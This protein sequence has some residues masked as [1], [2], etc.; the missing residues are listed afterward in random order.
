MPNG[1]APSAFRRHLLAYGASEAAG[2]ISRL[3][4]VVAV[5]RGLDPAAIGLA[6]A[7][8]AVGDILK[9]LTENGVGQRIVAAREEDLP[10]V[11]A[12]AHRIYWAWSLGLFAVQTLA[13]CLVWT[14][15]GDVLVAA[16]IGIL[17]AEY[18]FMPGGLVSCALA[19]REGKLSSTAAIAGG[20]VVAANMAT[21]ALA[22]LWA[23]PL[24]LVLPRVLSAP[25]WLVGMRRLR[26]WRH[27]RAVAPA[28]A[29]PFLRYGAAV[30]GV[31]FVKALRLHADKLVIGAILGA[32][33]LG[34]YFFA[35]N[36]GLGLAS[37]FSQAF[38]QVLFPHLAMAADRERALGSAMRLALL[39][40]VPVVALQSFA[41]PIYVPIL[42]G[43]GWE[44]VSGLVSILCLAAIPATIW[45]AA[46]QWLRARDRAGAE[47][48]ATACTAAALIGAT[49]A[50]APLGLEAVAIG[51]LAVASATQL[52][53]AWSAL[54]CTLLTNRKEA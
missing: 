47:F 17:G 39:V 26:P 4:V 10:A 15:S 18:L 8:L 30:L 45:T 3:A 2:K 43:A 33:A 42:F 49:A 9:A 51:Y 19:M 52:A 25:I 16:M 31:E 38:A 22:L 48:V 54:R 12:R 50:F 14:V 6:A 24:A 53:A 35:F 44:D 20:Q 5:A 13:A 23:N 46:A 21:A 36:A 27:D 1:P 11:C 37:S 7:A 41:A 29:A 28:P 32:E 40:I 34:I